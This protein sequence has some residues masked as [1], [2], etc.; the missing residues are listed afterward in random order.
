[1]SKNCQKNSQKHFA[2]LDIYKKRK[3][4]EFFM[5]SPD[6][7]HFI[8]EIN[9]GNGRIRHKKILNLNLQSILSRSK[10]SSFDFRLVLCRIR[11]FTTLISKIKWLRSGVP[12]NQN[13]HKIFNAL[14]HCNRILRIFQG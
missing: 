11:L 13:Q 6:Q 1:M 9:V 7:K 14:K 5:G 10:I 12:L 4:P 3:I 2:N 8:F